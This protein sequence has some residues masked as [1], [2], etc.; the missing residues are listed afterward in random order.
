MNAIIPTTEKDILLKSQYFVL[1][2]AED[3]YSNSISWGDNGEMQIKT[4]KSNNNF[5]IEYVPEIF[6]PDPHTSDIQYMNVPGGPSA[7]N[8]Q[9]DFMSHLM[10]TDIQYKV[11]N[12]LFDPKN[13]TDYPVILI[14]F[15][16][17]NIVTFG[18]TIA[19]Y[20]SQIFGV[21]VE[22]IDE[23]LRPNVFGNRSGI[24]P[25]NVEQGRKTIR[26]CKNSKF[27]KDI[28]LMITED[29]KEATSGNLTS[30]L[31]DYTTPELIYIYNT[32]FPDKPLYEGM[33]TREDM[34]KII[35]ESICGEIDFRTGYSYDDCKD[36]IGTYEQQLSD[37]ERLEED[38]RVEMLQSAMEES[39]Q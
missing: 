28:E 7:A 10:N 24:Y 36:A 38:F 26:M 22:F 32:L 30:Q 13:I 14:M 15:N 5:R 17:H 6:N 4:P 2:V 3:R 25:G 9:R 19:T 21:D 39:G 11:Y 34:M 20:L 18:S 27:M 33:Y 31:I 1:D 12:R 35:T 23:S 37:W 8:K 29:S 16:E